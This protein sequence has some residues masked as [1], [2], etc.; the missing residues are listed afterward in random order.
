MENPKMRGK[1]RK[2][3]ACLIAVVFIAAIFC[4]AQSP[5][6]NDSTSAAATV[7]VD[8][9]SVDTVEFEKNAMAL[10]V[11]VSPRTARCGKIEVIGSTLR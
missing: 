11:S 1:M 3:N 10:A 2:I 9:V 5:A 8:T 7:S 4:F 6:N